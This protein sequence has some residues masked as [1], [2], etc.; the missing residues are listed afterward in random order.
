[1]ARLS[2]VQYYETAF[3][4]ATGVSLKL[5]PPEP[6]GRRLT[7]GSAENPFC[8]LVSRSAAGCE[9]CV[10]D[11]S[12]LQRS[13]ARKLSPQQIHC[14]AGLTVVA[15][16]ILVGGRHVATLMSGQVFR[17]EPTQ[18]DFALVARMAAAGANGES[19]KDLRS[20][21]FDTPVVTAERFR[22]IVE[23]VNVFAQY[24]TGHASRCVIANSPEEPAAVTSAKEFLQSRIEQSVSLGEVARHVNVSP[25]HFCKLFKKATGMTFTEYVSRIRVEKAKTLLVDPSMRI[26]EI[27]FASGFGSIPRFNSV[28]K[29]Y[30]GKPPTQYRAELREQGAI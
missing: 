4:K 27:V 15:V 8:T 16:P 14:F 17:R 5:V 1:M 24:V 23:L 12:R 7:L 28:F 11:E 25:F 13:V 29:Q 10:A 20:A 22:A 2:V 3:R 21:F 26:S 9:A 6:T 30:V 18:R 19:D